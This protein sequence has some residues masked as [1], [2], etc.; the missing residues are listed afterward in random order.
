MTPVIF[1][2]VVGENGGTELR[3]KYNRA[4][5]LQRIFRQHYIIVAATH[6]TT[7]VPPT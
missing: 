1:N 4:I 3:P 7:G 6:Q 2:I 5:T